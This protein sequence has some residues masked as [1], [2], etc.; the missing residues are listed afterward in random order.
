MTKTSIECAKLLY[1]HNDDML[2]RYYTDA[3]VEKNDARRKLCFDH[4]TV[5]SH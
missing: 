3:E 4:A 5:L 1:S 2:F